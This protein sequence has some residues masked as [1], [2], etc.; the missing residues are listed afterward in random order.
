MR[1][2]AAFA[3]PMPLCDCGGDMTRVV[4][5]PRIMGDIGEYTSLMDGARITSRSHHREHMKVHGVEEL[6]DAKTRSL[7]PEKHHRDIDWKAATAEAA[8]QI[9]Q[10]RGAKWLK[11][12]LT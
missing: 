9:T 2:I 7:E 3:D 12:N 4:S 5:A 11:D 6:G 1:S 10:T 8:E